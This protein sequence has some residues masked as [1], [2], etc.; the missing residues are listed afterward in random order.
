MAAPLT[1][2]T[3]GGQD[4]SD[5]YVD[6]TTVTTDG[7]FLFPETSFSDEGITA[8]FGRSIWSFGINTHGQLGQQDTVPRSS[9]IRIGLLSDWKQVSGNGA[10]AQFGEPGYGS[11]AWNHFGVIK[12]NGALWVWGSNNAGR[13]GLNDSLVGRSSPIQVGTTTDW[14]NIQ[15]AAYSCLAIKKNNTLWAWGR[16]ARGQ[17]GDNSTLNRSSPVQ[18]GTSGVW[19]TTTG[20][21]ASAAITLSG[22]L[23]TWGR[24]QRGQLGANTTVNR[25]SPAQVGT[26]SDWKD[27]VINGDHIVALKTDNTLW[28]WGLNFSGRLGLNDTLNRS[29]PVQVGTLRDWYKL[30]SIAIGGPII[31]KSNGSLWVWGSNATGSSGALG[32]NDSIAR[33][34]PVQLGTLNDWKDVAGGYGHCLAIK[35]DGSL[36]GWGIGT[37]GRLGLSNTINRSS[38]VRIGSLSNWKSISAAWSSSLARKA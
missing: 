5:I 26:G 21:E 15:T 34:S 18:V 33:S 1:N 14:K 28:T 13:L 10:L 20:W 4:L 32:L 23:W 22:T 25:S 6:Q 7:D 19:K 38:P 16:N 12:T 3:A 24:N 9:P 30:G 35:T 11:P 37:N 31:I 8:A 29:S 2:F 27:I 36:W 17:L